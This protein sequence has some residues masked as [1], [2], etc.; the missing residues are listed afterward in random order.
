MSM[1][2]YPKDKNR[3]KCAKWNYIPHVVYIRKSFE[4]MHFNMWYEE[5]ERHLYNMFQI[6]GKILYDRNRIK[7]GVEYYDSFVRLIYSTSSKYIPDY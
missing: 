1:S 7:M 5:N 4:K 3:V 2:H 6:F